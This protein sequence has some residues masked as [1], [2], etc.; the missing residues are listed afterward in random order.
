MNNNNTQKIITSAVEERHEER[1]K[2]PYLL[3]VNVIITLLSIGANRRVVNRFPSSTSRIGR[4]TFVEN[5]VENKFQIEGTY[6]EPVKGS[7]IISFFAISSR[8][9]LALC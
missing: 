6:A 5:F 8:N 4:T 9:L 3:D 2:T 7:Q 1:T